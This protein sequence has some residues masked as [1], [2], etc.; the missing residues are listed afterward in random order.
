MASCSDDGRVV[1]IGLYGSDNNQEF[2]FDRPIKAVSLDPGFYRPNMGR[3]Y[4]TGDEKLTLHEK[5]FL[6]RHK[7]TILHDG[8][9]PIRNI[10]WRSYFIAWTNDRGIKVYDM[11][12]K[13]RITYIQKDIDKSLRSEI[14]RC[15]LSWKDD[16]TLLIGWADKVKICVIRERDRNDVRDLPSRYVEIVA[17][18][19]TDFYICGIAPMADKLV[20]LTYEK[21][22]VTEG[23]KVVANRPHLQ[24]IDPKVDSYE[25]IS[26]DALSIR[27]FQEYRCSD[28]HLESIIEENLFYIISPKDVVVAK[29]RDLDD[30][31]DWLLQHEMYEEA[32][33]DASKNSREL[34]RNSYQEIGRLYLMHLLEEREFEE[35]AKLCVKILGKSKE[36]WEDAIYKF[37]QSR[38]LRVIAPYIPTGRGQDVKLSEPIYEMVLNDFL[39]SDYEGFKRR[40]KEW[41][42]GLYNNQVLVNAVLDRLDSDE[43]NITLLECLGELYTNARQFDKSLAIF[44]RLQHPEV[45]QLI[46]KHNLFDSIADKIVML[47]KFNREKAVEMFLDNMDK[48][49]I[50]EVVH[51]LEKTPELLHV[52][53]DRL[54][55]KDHH[56]GQEF[57][58][59]QVKLYAEYDRSKLLS[60]LRSSNYYP[61]QKALEECQQRQLYP[62]MVFLLGR[63]GNTKQAL[64]LITRELGDVSQAIE[65]CKEHNDQ[66]LWDD[67]IDFSIGKPLFIKGLLNNI[68]THVD[69]IILIKKIR[70]GMEIP[71]LRDSLVKI[72]H[73]YNLQMSLR[74]GCQKILVKDCYGLL[75][76]LVKTQRRGICVDSELKCQT[77]H[78]TILVRDMRFASDVVIFYCRHAFHEDCLPANA[79]ENC[80]ICNAQRRGPGSTITFRK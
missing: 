46:H 13:Q 68:G 31:L 15:H 78:N 34:K 75:E 29:P 5:G 63:M 69:P 24:V 65:F 60:F 6:S 37:A 20:L 27:G 11:S 12:T 79:T 77:C 74:E 4:V 66:D 53:L 55:Q 28:Y 2:Q 58:A 80:S 16:R 17:M 41:P 7:T 47:M 52:Y 40:I 42:L 51:Q 45:F 14:Y 72:L 43:T 61:L 38:Q 19:D 50:K 33:E 64:M 3:Q 23:G 22:E 26:D 73:D 18:F 25:E 76:R 48:V 10:K 44:L 35:A 8:E 9:G 30:H 71:G 21:E 1:I 57:H 56:I 54:F 59:L 32:M 49:P 70:E 39:Q 67:L 62:E 36:A